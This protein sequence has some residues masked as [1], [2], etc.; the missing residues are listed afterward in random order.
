VSQPKLPRNRALESE[1]LNVT[2]VGL[3]LIVAAIL[4]VLLFVR[5]LQTPKP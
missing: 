2:L 5:F 3:A 4:A 1:G